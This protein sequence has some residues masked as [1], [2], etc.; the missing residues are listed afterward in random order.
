MGTKKTIDGHFCET[1]ARAFGDRNEISERLKE[2]GFIVGAT[3]FGHL[4]V[5]RECE[6]IITLD[7]G[8]K[9]TIK[10]GRAT[11]LLFDSKTENMIHISSGNVYSPYE[12]NTALGNL[13]LKD[14]ELII[15]GNGN[16]ALEEEYYIRVMDMIE[17]ATAAIEKT[18]VLTYC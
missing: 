5:A 15:L 4:T 6:E 14:G 3:R 12:A 13:S 8:T 11:E 17:K 9:S 2:A 18:P 1:L 10:L 7:D 16:P